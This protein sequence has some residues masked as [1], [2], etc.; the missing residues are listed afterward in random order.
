MKTQD[1]LLL[2][3]VGVLGWWFYRL[4]DQRAEAISQIA[5]VPQT[6][7]WTPPFVPTMPRIRLP[8]LEPNPV[9]NAAVIVDYDIQPLEYLQ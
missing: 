5:D 1:V 6:A 4:L 7:P 3:A 8:L 2:V 9:E